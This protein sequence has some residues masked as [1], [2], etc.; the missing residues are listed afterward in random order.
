MLADKDL[1]QG[2]IDDLVDRLKEARENKSAEEEG[3]RQEVRAQTRLAALY[4]KQAEEADEKAGK[5]AK[6][7]S[8]L[9]VLLGQAEDRYE[10]LQFLEFK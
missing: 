3:F 10:Q 8:E 7:V 6:S 1:L 5:F 2:R 9:Q 4:Q